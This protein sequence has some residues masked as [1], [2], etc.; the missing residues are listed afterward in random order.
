M[1]IEPAAG[2]FRFGDTACAE[3]AHVIVLA[4]F[5]ALGVGVTQ[6]DQFSFHGWNLASKGSID[7]AAV[8]P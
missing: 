1:L 7:T 6:Q 3:W 5:G 4:G 8:R 2:V